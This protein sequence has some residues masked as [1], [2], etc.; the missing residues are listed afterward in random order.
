MVG[1]KAA[2]HKDIPGWVL[3]V[4]I[5]LYSIYIYTYI[6]T[7]QYTYTYDTY[8]YNVYIYNIIRIH[9]YIYI[10]TLFTYIMRVVDIF[11]FPIGTHRLQAFTPGELVLQSQEVWNRMDNWVYLWERS[12][13]FDG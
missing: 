8:V 1:R 6:H 13:I 10:H 11:G 2:Q 3:D 4:P 7:V 12:A 9:I 5:Y